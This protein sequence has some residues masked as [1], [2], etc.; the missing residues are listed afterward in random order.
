MG[1]PNI[2]NIYETTSFTQDIG[3]GRVG[4]RIFAKDFLEFLNIHYEDVTDA[5]RYRIIDSDYLASV[6]LYEIKANYK[7]DKQIIIEEYTNINE[8][9][10]RKSY[11]WFYKSKADMLVFIS[12]KTR[13]M[14]LIP[15]T[16]GFKEYYESI[17]DN[18]ELKWNKISVHNGRRWQ[19]AYRRIPL[20]KL[21]GYFAYY[22]RAL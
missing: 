14:I 20:D 8:M 18:Y 15:F 17:K 13:A 1:Q 4:E 3:R 22:K 5:Q 9:L 7:D 19:S 2:M 12:K 6:G 10:S 21:S 16:D 11:G